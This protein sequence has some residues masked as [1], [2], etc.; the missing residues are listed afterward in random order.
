MDPS[1]THTYMVHYGEI[2]LKGKNRPDFEHQ[3]MRNI[4]AQHEGVEVDRLRGR[5]IVSSSRPVDL[6]DVFGIAWWSQAEGVDSN[7]EAI[8]H[9]VIRH[10]SDRVAQC[11]TFAIRVTRADKILGLTSQEIEVDL[12]AHVQSEFDLAVDLDNPDLT[13]YVEILRDRTFIYTDRQDGLRGLP[14]GVSGGLTGLFSGGID[15]AVAA[16]LM[17]KRGA[18]LDLVHFHAYGRPERAYDGKLGRLASVLTRYV[19]RLRL[20]LLPY[21]RFQLATASLDRSQRQ[22]LVVF[23]RFMVR[24]AER[25]ADQYGSLGLFTGD[26]LG[27]VASQTLENLAAV[28]I[29]TGM[30]IFRPLIAYDKQEI[31]D[32]GSRLGV[33]EIATE[34]YKDCCSIV[35]RHPATRANLE[36]VRYIE[37]RIEVEALV[38]ATLGDLTTVEFN[39]QEPGGELLQPVV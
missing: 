17:A 32:F 16:F 29:V 34:P 5:L 30:P 39:Q 3:L 37:E 18:T 22:E 10:I 23:R 14:V 8:R 25:L 13:V 15:S 11:D 21:D 28:Q 4:R 7:L 33:A 6:G 27:Q 31:I 26:N 12:G 38:E 36:K 24:V 2:A 1:M 19:P 9:A 20:H 35:A